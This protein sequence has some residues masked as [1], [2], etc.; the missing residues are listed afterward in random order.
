M[1]AKPTSMISKAFLTV[2]LGGLFSLPMAA[3]AESQR[4]EFTKENWFPNN[5]LWEVGARLKLVEFND[6]G[7]QFSTSDYNTYMA[8][9]YARYGLTDDLSLDIAIPVGV[10][11]RDVGSDDSGLGNIE[12]GLQLRAHEHVTDY[13]FVI[14]HAELILDTADSDTLLDDGRDGVN[15]GVSV[16][17]RRNDILIWVA[18]VG[19]SVRSDRENSLQAS[20][21]LIAEVNDRFSFIG[22]ARVTDE[23]DA[24]NDTPVRFLGGLA[25]DWSRSLQVSLYAGGAVNSDEDVVTMLKSSYSF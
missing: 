20:L 7:E 4:T 2:T 9:P 21:S 1:S 5:E 25:Y 6:Q 14:P 17:T 24:E 8:V 16:G 10:A 13:P 15:F 22:E 12:I 19:Y 11:E 18:D 23:D 3:L